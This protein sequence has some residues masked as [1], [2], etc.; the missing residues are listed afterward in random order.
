MDSSVRPVHDQQTGRAYNGLFESVCCRQLA[1][2]NNHGDSLAA[3]LRSV[4]V[5]SAPDWDGWL[6]PEKGRPAG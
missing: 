3:K 2:F 5:S 6:P 1:V 4:N